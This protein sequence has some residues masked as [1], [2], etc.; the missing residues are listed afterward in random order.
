M[1][2]LQSRYAGGELPGIRRRSCAHARPGSSGSV[3]AQSQVEI[4]D[5]PML[6][7]HARLEGIVQAEQEHTFTRRSLSFNSALIVVS[8]ALASTASRRCMLPTAPFPRGAEARRR[9]AP[10]RFV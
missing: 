5:G 1:I 3:L 7:P 9:P 10:S 2:P 4:L 6:L 8:G